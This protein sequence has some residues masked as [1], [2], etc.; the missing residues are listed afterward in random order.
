VGTGHNLRVMASAPQ[1]RKGPDE[2]LS[3]QPPAWV[4]FAWWAVLAA[5]II[6]SMAGDPST[7]CS[8]QSPCQPDPVF[9]VVVALVGL[10]ALTIWHFP[11]TGLA[12]GAGYAVLG[13]LFDP[14]HAGRYADAVAGAVALGLLL[15]VNALRTRQAQLGERNCGPDLGTRWPDPGGDRPRTT[16]GWKSAVV[17]A[18]GAVGLLLLLS[19]MAAY[20]HQTSVERAHLDR[21]EAAQAR[22]VT[23]TDDDYRQAFAIENGARAGDRVRIEVI[24]E[25]AKG[26]V[27][28]ILLDPDDPSWV[29]L[30][31]EPQGFTSWFGWGLLGGA[32][33]VW[34]AG[35]E[36]ARV[37]AQRLRGP[38]RRYQVRLL[39][40]GAAELVLAGGSHPVAVVP[41]AGDPDAPRSRTPVPARV[42][43]AVADGSWVRIQTEF[44][45]LPVVGPLRANPPWRAL[46]IGAG[47]GE[48]S[49]TVWARVAVVGQVL[50]RVLLVALGC[51]LLW[52]GLHQAGPA[53]AAAHGRGVTGQVTVTSESCGGK[54]GC[55]YS[56]DFRSDA[57]GYSFTD[58]ELVGASGQVGSA[59]PAYYE[60]QGDTPDAVYGHGWAALVE[61]GFFIGLAVLTAGE[62]LLRLLTVLTGRRR[63][64]SGRHAAG[65][66]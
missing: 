8:V 64:P 41:L 10:S 23:Y 18:A 60:G 3:L 19:S 14:S 42:W 62:P 55:H 15:M 57:G 50:G 4:P 58:V 35:H 49:E 31:S 7:G 51:G 32:V 30:V 17:P 56:G 37:R 46:N 47:L 24:D 28:P 22:V 9:P 45:N 34:C 53:W 61:S 52:F 20:L 25:L 38:A 6:A 21:A 33:A 44:E 26:Q 43:G 16:W 1:R 63:P 12:A 40:N 27:W 2:W 66:T 39:G 59:V 36:V 29:R 65:R 13:V 54:G 48:L 5:S 11:V